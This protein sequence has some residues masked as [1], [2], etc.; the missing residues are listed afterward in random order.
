VE[1]AWI[2]RVLVRLLNRDR[3]SP[4]AGPSVDTY[5][6]AKFGVLRRAIRRI[7][8]LAR[9]CRVVVVLPRHHP[10]NGLHR[11]QRPVIEQLFRGLD[12]TV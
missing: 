3:C 5:L 7:L 8:T 6:D 2:Q 4:R 1:L 12:A 10:Q 11:V 9:E